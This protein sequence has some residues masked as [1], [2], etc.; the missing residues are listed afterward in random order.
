MC[1]NFAA[2]PAKYCALSKIVLSWGQSLFL[3]RVW[4]AGMFDRLTKR[5]KNW[6]YG[7]SDI[8][9]QLGFRA[10]TDPTVK[11]SRNEQARWK[12][13][14]IAEHIEKLNDE[15]LGDKKFDIDETQAHYNLATTIKLLDKKR[16]ET[17]KLQLA[18]W[19]PTG[20]ENVVNNLQLVAHLLPDKRVNDLRAQGYIRARAL[21]EKGVSKGGL[22]CAKDIYAECQEDHSVRMDALKE[23]VTVC[24]AYDRYTHNNPKSR[25]GQK[26]RDRLWFV[27]AVRSAAIKTASDEISKQEELDRQK[28][29]IDNEIAN[30]RPMNTSMRPWTAGMPVDP[31]NMVLTPSSIQ[32]LNCSRNIY[33]GII[34]GSHPAPPIQISVQ[35]ST[36]SIRPQVTEESKRQAEAAAQLQQEPSSMQ[37]PVPNR[38]GPQPKINMNAMFEEMAYEDEYLN[39]HKNKQSRIN[40]EKQQKK[41]AKKQRQREKKAQ[42]GN[43]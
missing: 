7:E 35:S 39:R 27:K 8:K 36:P 17:P 29:A 1:T 31:S 4:D 38:K 23:L 32:P 26:G 13:F 20:Y 34:Q 37:Q 5:I 21:K 25:S 18:G 9:R 22:D 40:S 33:P 43:K 15:K 2:I 19:E 28:N 14:E 30:I 12:R 11:N 3:K 10:N 6:W 41:A 16:R 42:E 24:E